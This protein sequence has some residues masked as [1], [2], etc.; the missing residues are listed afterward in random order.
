MASASTC[1]ARLVV[2]RWLTIAARI[3]AR[4]QET[5]V[6]ATAVFCDVEYELAWVDEGECERARTNEY[7]RKG[8]SL[9]QWSSMV[10]VRQWHNRNQVRDVTKPDLDQIGHLFVEEAKMYAP[11]AGRDDNGLVIEC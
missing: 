5:P 4:G 2:A 7:L 10:S 9:K 1:L 3:N 8:Q 6:R 11:D